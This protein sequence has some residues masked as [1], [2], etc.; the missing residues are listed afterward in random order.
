M[1]FLRFTDACESDLLVSLAD[2]QDVRQAHGS[3]A[4]TITMRGGACYLLPCTMRGY[5]AKLR[6][7]ETATARVIILEL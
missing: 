3:G 1:I 7:V 6:E 5:L 4:A 2:V